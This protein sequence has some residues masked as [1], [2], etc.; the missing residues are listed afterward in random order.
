[1]FKFLFFLICELE[2]ISELR[3]KDEEITSK[4]GVIQDGIP[5]MVLKRIMIKITI[6]Y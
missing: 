3:M 1:M 6:T 4:F 5:T 2:E